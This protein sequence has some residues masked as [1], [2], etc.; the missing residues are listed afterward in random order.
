M[1][2]NSVV[3]PVGLKRVMC[4]AAVLTALAVGWMSWTLFS[5]YQFASAE[6]PRA[7]QMEELHGR[8]VLLDALSTMSA[9]MSAASSDPQWATK[10]HQ[11][12]TEQD[13]ALKKVRGL[14]LGTAANRVV[15]QALEINNWTDAIELQ[16]LKL[17]DQNRRAEAAALLE[18]ADYKAHEKQYG[19]SMVQ[20]ESFLKQ[21]AS[22]AQEHM[23]QDTRSSF[24]V[25]LVVVLMLV[26]C[27]GY[28]LV[29]MR[30]WQSILLETNRL[31]NDKS[32]L[33]EQAN[34]TLNERSRQLSETNEKLEGQSRQLMDANQRLS[35]Q[36][37]AL[38][39]RSKQ[40]Q[41]TNQ[42]LEEQSRQLEAFSKEL[43]KKVAERTR[44]LRESELALLNMMSDTVRSRENVQRALDDLQREVAE[45]KKVE[46]QLAQSQKMD[47]IGQLAGGVA[48][49]F[50]NQ[51]N[52]IM[53]FAGLLSERLVDSKQKRYADNIL[54]SAQRSADLTKKLLAFSRKGQFQEVPV[55]VHKLI[56]E[57]ADML[58]RSIDKRIELKQSLQAESDIVNGDPSQLQN[59]FLNL[60][61]NARDAMPQGGRLHFQTDVVFLDPATAAKFGEAGSGQYVRICLSDTGT[62]MSDEVKRHLFEPFFT[63]KPLGKGTGMGLASVFGTI[64]SHKGVIDVYSEVGHGTTFKLYL[65][66]SEPAA[67]VETNGTG[68]R[69]RTRSIRVLLVEDEDM[70]REMVSEMLR[71]GG[72]EIVEAENGRKALEMYGRDWRN[73]DVVILDMIMPEMN[74]PDTFHQMKKINPGIK[75]LLATGF[76]IN[77][78]VQA[79][80]DDGVNGFIQKPFLPN[81]LLDKIAHVMG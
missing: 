34:G 77:K 54:T 64:K 23:R 49:D 1:P 75:A 18:S 62:G 19:D 14:A 2:I 58:E 13:E 68:Q 5:T 47:A 8:V 3:N 79:A 53:G 50:N 40:L 4:L 51:L 7:L 69:A 74:G 70:L 11:F 52:A 29:L 44:Q 28:V 55:S 59:A 65:P 46:A 36:T 57:T 20:L 37:S 33:L 17:I 71:S 60:A 56:G 76:S 41:E 45:R 80:L 27:W 25:V 21:A 16:A 24:V 63:T 73:I 30:Q 35:E 66:L 26:I 61:V 15:E 10:Y 81:D 22:D 43:D 6:I 9:R 31:S 48:H 32:R 39:D 42:T 67:A 38:N 78:E 72:H 12:E